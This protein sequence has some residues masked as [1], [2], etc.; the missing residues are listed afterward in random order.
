MCLAAVPPQVP[1]LVMR[2]VQQA[3]SCTP[4]LGCPTGCWK[5][6]AR[7]RL[8]FG[9]ALRSAQSLLRA[10]PPQRLLLAVA[11]SVFQMPLVNLNWRVSHPGPPLLRCRLLWACWSRGVSLQ[12]RACRRVHSLVPSIA[13]VGMAQLAGG[14][15]PC[16]CSCAAFVRSCFA[17][18]ANF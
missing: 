4:C 12:R 15:V 2:I 8:L 3:G 11:V 5:Q 17:S 10:P 18:R 16:V 13:L 7:G 14:G 6:N 1:F 9:V